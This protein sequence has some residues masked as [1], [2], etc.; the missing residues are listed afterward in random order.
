[1]PLQDWV[2]SK[3]NLAFAEEELGGVSGCTHLDN[4]FPS[5]D[6]MSDELCSHIQKVR[7]IFVD[8][9]HLW[10]RRDIGL[11]TEGRVCTV[12]ARLLLLYESETKLLWVCELLVFGHCSV[13]GIG[14]IILRVIQELE[15]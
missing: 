2:G 13:R 3:P 8:L 11:W 1:M 7:S 6:L 14:G 10:R 15:V 12:A 5:R 9:R 4:C